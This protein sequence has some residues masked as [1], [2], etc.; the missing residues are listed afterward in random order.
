MSE[1]H[2]PPVVHM[3]FLG[4]MTDIYF[5]LHVNE[6]LFPIRLSQFSARWPFSIVSGHN[7]GVHKVSVLRFHVPSDVHINISD[8]VGMKPSTQENVHESPVLLLQLDDKTALPSDSGH[9]IGK[10]SVSVSTFHFPSDV[11]IK[12]DDVVEKKPFMQ[13]KRH[14]SPIFLLQLGDNTALSRCIGHNVSLHNE[15]IDG[16][17]IPVVLQV[18]VAVL[19]IR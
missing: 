18:A 19:A 6:H 15:S 7:F 12:V 14:R 1:L 2:N 8:V 11:H 16:T 9:N 5:S 10:H 3:M 4:S 13:L 17:H